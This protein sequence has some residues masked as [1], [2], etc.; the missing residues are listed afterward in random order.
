MPSSPGP[1]IRVIDDPETLRLIAEPLRLRLLELLRR[2]PRTVSELATEL[3]LPRTNLYYHIGLLEKHGLVQVAETRVVSGITEKRYRASAFRLSVRKSLIGEGADGA[4]PLAV[5]LSFVLD[6]VA[7]EIRRAV[8]SGLIQLEGSDLDSFRPGHLVLGRTWF[9]FTDDEV[10]AFG[11]AMEA[12]L[13]R[14]AA[15]RMLGH[16]EPAS[17]LPPARAGTRLYEN[18]T[19]FYPVIP[20][21]EPSDA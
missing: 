10:A 1:D 3:E 16:D 20:P 6:E 9:S 21:E 15:Q 2:A 18:L 11:A 13:D 14:F 17:P 4:T 7:S 12:V 8:E 19:A 5:Y